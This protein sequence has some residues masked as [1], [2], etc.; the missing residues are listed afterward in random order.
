MSPPIL[1]DD[2]LAKVVCEPFLGLEELVPPG[3]DDP[4]D[5]VPHEHE[6]AIAREP[7][8]VAHGLLPRE[9]EEEGRG[10]GNLFRGKGLVLMASNL[11]CFKR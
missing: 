1:A 10:I 2:S 7:L 5:G 6:G 3:G 11:I 9:G 8:G 4:F